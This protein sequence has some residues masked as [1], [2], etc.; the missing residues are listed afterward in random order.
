[1]NRTLLLWFLQRFHSEFAFQLNF[2]SDRNCGCH[3]KLLHLRENNVTRVRRKIPTERL[4]PKPDRTQTIAARSLRTVL[5]FL[6]EKPWILLTW[7]LLWLMLR[8]LFGIRV[9]VC[10]T[11]SLSSSRSHPFVLAAT[12][13]LT[14]V[15][16][17]ST[18]LNKRSQ[19]KGPY[20]ND[21]HHREAAIHQARWSRKAFRIL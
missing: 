15:S 20:I 17:A 21:C 8:L 9:S 2:L 19:R 16:E 1:M 7:R 10:K 18:S 14:K 11:G 12:S 6:H 3:S 4:N 13:Y 5:L